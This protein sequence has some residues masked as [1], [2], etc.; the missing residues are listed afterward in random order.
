MT[1]L[2]I[3]AL[4]VAA[5]AKATM[6]MTTGLTALRGG[7]GSIACARRR[8][9]PFLP[10][11]GLLAGVP[12]VA[13]AYA[14]AALGPTND[15]IH[16][17]VFWLGLLLFV[18]P[19]TLR[20][21]DAVTARGER[22]AIV[23]ATGLFF[24]LPKFLRNPTAPLFQDELAHWHQ[25]ET[26]YHTGQPFAPNPIISIIGSFP[27][28][29][30]LTAALH[31]LSG[32]STVRVGLVILLALHAISLIGIFVLAERCTGSPRVAGLA[33]LIYSLNPGYMFFDTMYAYESPAIVL[34]I[35][36]LAAVAGLQD[37]TGGLSRQLAWGGVGLVL[38]AACIVT[39][40]L[41]ALVMVATLLLIALATAIAARRASHSVS[42]CA[43]ES[44]RSRRTALLTALF[45]GVVT[46]GA[47]LWLGAVAIP[48]VR[49][50]AP[51]AA[52]LGDVLRLLGREGSG[53]RTLFAGSTTP[54]YERVCAYLAPVVALAGATAGLWLLWRRGWWNRYTVAGRA[55]A[56]YGLLYF[57]SLPLLLT[58]SGNEGARRSW[59]FTYVGLSLLVAP[60]IPALLEGASRWYQGA[61]RRGARLL[62]HVAQGSIAA[63][64][65]V[66]LVGNVTAHVNE[67]YRFP[68]PFVYG[69]DTRS[70]TPELLALA[71]WLDRTQGTGR[72]IVA[73]RFSGL[74]LAAFGGAWTATASPQFPLWQLYFQDRQPSAAL[75]REVRSAGYG[76]IVVDRRMSQALPRIGIYFDPLEPAAYAHATPPPAS[77]LI[78]YE[79][80]PWAT[81]IYQSDNLAVY[82]LASHGHGIRP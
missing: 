67:L 45:A 52:G 17:D 23:A 32:L 46:V 35:W 60:A 9:L 25:A 71:R 53:A 56:L 51:S 63:L 36:V 2:A 82:R 64:I 14:V 81:T 77:A 62:A 69:S 24:Y 58:Q 54:V 50:L 6:A 15:R 42:L 41:S 59:S 73:D 79:Q 66:V 49:Y 40:H 5:R 72:H 19:A 31:D 10:W 44:A 7:A 20:L 48:L 28:L 8:P 38:A 29:P 68:G 70:T 55:I 11:I 18:V 26:V 33:A 1:Q 3:P 39:H 76:Y 4:G 16:F 34:Y 75:L 21:C 27:G 65:A 80:R 57:P 43:S 22:L 37:E 12:L 30:T 13:A 47:A 78:Q 61:R 74:P